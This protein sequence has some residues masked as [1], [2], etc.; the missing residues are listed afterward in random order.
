[1]SLSSPLPWCGRWVVQWQM[2]GN[3][4]T[5]SPKPRV[6]PPRYVWYAPDIAQ[7]CLTCL[8]CTEDKIVNHRR[9]FSS[10]LRRWT[11]HTHTHFSCVWDI[12]WH[13]GRFCIFLILKSALYFFTIL[14][15]IFE[16]FES[17]ES[18][19]MKRQVH[20]AWGETPRSWGVLRLPIWGGEQGRRSWIMWSWSQR[21]VISRIRHSK[22]PVTKLTKLKSTAGMGSLGENGEVTWPDE[23]WKLRWDKFGPTEENTWH[24][25]MRDGE[26]TTK[27]YSISNVNVVWK[28]L[29]GA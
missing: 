29:C 1:M 6:S 26:L 20:G 10:F 19:H 3:S 25:S 24:R 14:S 4:E 27:S 9:A 5:Q 11:S 22:Y 17:F 8:T 12:I 18:F 2:H 15:L 21:I 7:I 16:S 28:V 23:N 13:F